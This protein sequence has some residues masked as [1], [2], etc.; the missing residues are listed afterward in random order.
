M[1]KVLNRCVS[2][3]DIINIREG[4]VK[5]VGC[6]GWRHGMERWGSEVGVKMARRMGG[7]GVGE[8]R[9]IKGG[10]REGRATLL[11]FPVADLRKSKSL[12]QTRDHQHH[13][14]IKTGLPGKESLDSQC[15][16]L[17]RLSGQGKP[18]KPE[19]FPATDNSPHTHRGQD[20]ARQR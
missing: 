17:R 15:L 5:G 10:E 16:Y 6:T 19:P 12:R 18:E 3:N 13:C 4:G 1:I 8:G 7:E 14:V 9:E 2:I 20:K 11:S